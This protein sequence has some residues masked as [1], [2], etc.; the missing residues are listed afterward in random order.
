[1]KDVLESYLDRLQQATTLE[2]LFLATENLRDHYGV[3]HVVYH[4]VSS[5]GEQYGA[6]TYSTE[7]VDRYLERGYVRVDPVVLGCINRFHP[8][9]WKQLNWSSKGAREFLSD[10]VAHGVGNQGLSVPVHGPQG[11]FAMFTVNHKCSDDDWNV[12]VQAHLR[13]F[14]LIAHEF[15][16]KALEFERGERLAPVAMLSPRE[17]SAMTLL[18]KGLSRSQAAAELEISE[19]TLRVYIEAARHKLGA[20][21]TTHAVARALS[22]GLIVV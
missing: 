1:M 19:H 3:S 8:V 14:I 9:D 12:F 2:D 21:N 10:A 13:E 17:L 6:G 18:A 11:Q 15:N 16:R 5:V 20:I 22:A 7:W 4:W